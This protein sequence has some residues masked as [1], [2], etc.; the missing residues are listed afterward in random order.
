[1][2]E[3]PCTLSRGRSVA[4]SLFTLGITGGGGGGAR[5]NR[6]EEDID[7]PGCTAQP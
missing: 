1:M 2:A 5:G 7:A 4:R 3:S 6:V